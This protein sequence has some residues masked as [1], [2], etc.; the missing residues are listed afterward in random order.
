MEEFKI[1]RKYNEGKNC[2]KIAFTD[3]KS[4]RNYIMQELS[5]RSN[6]LEM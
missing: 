2:Q 6:L 4:Q 3:R 1:A 5:E